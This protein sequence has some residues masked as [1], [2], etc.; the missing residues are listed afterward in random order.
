MDGVICFVDRRST[1]IDQLKSEMSRELKTGIERAEEGAT[2]NNLILDIFN[3][4]CSRW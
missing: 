4:H 3:F 2:V 1:S